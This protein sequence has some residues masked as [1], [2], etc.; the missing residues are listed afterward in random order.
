MSNFAIEKFVQLC[1]NSLR[2]AMFG[3]LDYK[4]HSSCRHRGKRMPFVTVT[5]DEPGGGV[6]G[7]NRECPGMR[8]QRPKLRKPTTDFFAHDDLRPTP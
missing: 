8:R 7:E 3:S 1:M 6:N 4:G 5:N 2:I